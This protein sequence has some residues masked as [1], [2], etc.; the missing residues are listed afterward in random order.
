MN[1]PLGTACVHCVW[2]MPLCTSSDSKACHASRS[3]AACC[4]GISKPWASTNY[5]LEA[6]VR[7]ALPEVLVTS[8][9]TLPSN[10]CCGLVD[11]LDG[12]APPSVPPI[13]GLAFPSRA[14]AAVRVPSNVSRPSP[15]LCGY[16]RVPP[17]YRCL[18]PESLGPPRRKQSGHASSSLATIGT[19]FAS[20]EVG[21]CATC[22]IPRHSNVALPLSTTS[23]ETQQDG[24]P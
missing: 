6:L 2:R 12:M 11:C 19:L 22:S 3:C 18:V 9:L 7:T 24:V 17:W 16:R 5:L 4:H 21:F 1:L 15:P 13:C 20:W 10:L 14:A 23:P 8:S